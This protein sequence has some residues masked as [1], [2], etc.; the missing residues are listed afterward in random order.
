MT[1]SYI[2]YAVQGLR[3]DSWDYGSINWDEATSMLKEQGHG[4]IAAIEVHENPICDTCIEEWDY[5]ELFD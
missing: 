1:K 2:F 4:L 3:S 5:A